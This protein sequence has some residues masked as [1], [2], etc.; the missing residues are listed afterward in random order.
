MRDL[1]QI[2][3]MARVEPLR[4]WRPS[5]CHEQGRDVA[6]SGHA[7]G[8]LVGHNGLYLNLIILLPC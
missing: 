1:A 8:S 3:A 2:V 6:P 4:S 7:H 5:H